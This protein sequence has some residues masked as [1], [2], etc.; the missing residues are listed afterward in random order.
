M[1][2]DANA[3]ELSGNSNTPKL[4]DDANA[5]EL[6]DE[7]LKA[8][9]IK[10]FNDAKKRFYSV[11]S[12]AVEKVEFDK[13]IGE[14]IRT[15]QNENAQIVEKAL[16]DGIYNYV[17][18]KGKGRCIERLNRFKTSIEEAEK[19]LANIKEKLNPKL[20]SELQSLP[21]DSSRRQDIQEQ[22]KRNKERIA[23][24][25]ISIEHDL[26]SLEDSAAHYEFFDKIN[27][28]AQKSPTPETMRQLK[29]QTKRINNAI[30]NQKEIRETLK[31]HEMDAKKAL[32]LLSK[33]EAELAQHILS[34]PPKTSIKDIEK[35]RLKEV[36]QNMLTYIQAERNKRDASIDYELSRKIMENASKNFEA[37][38]D[39]T[40]ELKKQFARL[41]KVRKTRDAYI[42]DLNDAEDR[43]LKH[44]NEGAAVA[45]SI[46]EM[47]KA[48]Q[49]E[50]DKTKKEELIAALNMKLEA[51]KREAEKIERDID[52]A[53]RLHAFTNKLMEE[54]S[55]TGDIKKLA[56]QTAELKIA[57]D[58]QKKYSDRLAN[59]EKKIANYKNSKKSH[60]KQH[61]DLR[62]AQL[63][64]EREDA[65][66]A[67]AMMGEL[68]DQA[69]EQ[70][71]TSNLSSQVKQLREGIGGK[72]KY[73]RR[74]F[75][76]TRNRLA[77]EKA[78][79][80]LLQTQIRRKKNKKDLDARSKHLAESEANLK[81]EQENV[82][83][84]PENLRSLGNLTIDNIRAVGALSVKDA[85]LTLDEKQKL[86][87]VE[88]A[89][90][91]HDLG[92]K[93]L[94]KARKDKSPAKL[95]EQ[96]KLMEAAV[97][98]LNKLRK[99]LEYEEDRQLKKKNEIRKAEFE[100]TA[101]KKRHDIEKTI[102][103]GKTP[104]TED[105]INQQAIVNKHE[106]KLQRQEWE[107][108]KLKRR[109]AE[110]KIFDEKRLANAEKNARDANT[111]LRIIADPNA[112]PANVKNAKDKLAA[113]T[114][115]I[116]A[117]KKLEKKLAPPARVKERD[118]YRE[119]LEKAE[120]KR[121]EHTKKM[122]A[123][124][125]EELKIKIV[126]ANRQGTAAADA[127]LKELEEKRG[128]WL[129]IRGAQI[130][131][132]EKDAALLYEFSNKLLQESM[133]DTSREKAKALK[134]QFKALR[135][136]NNIQKDLR[137]RIKKID[138]KMNSRLYA[139]LNL[140]TK[141]QL[142]RQ[143]DDLTFGHQE[144]QKLIETALTKN[145]PDPIQLAKDCENLREGIGGRRKYT[146]RKFGQE[147]NREVLDKYESL[148]TKNKDKLKESEERLA[149]AEA[150]Q[151]E[152]PNRYRRALEHRDDRKRLQEQS[153]RRLTDA[154]S[155]YNIGKELLRKAVA[156]EPK[157]PS[158]SQRLAGLKKQFSALESAIKARNK[159]ASRL[160]KIEKNAQ[161]TKRKDAKKIKAAEK[162]LA[163]L[164]KRLEK[165]SKNL[166]KLDPNDKNYDKKLE[167][168]LAK[169]DALQEKIENQQDKIGYLKD[170]QIAN[171]TRNN[172]LIE[173][174][175]GLYTRAQGVV[176]DV[177]SGKMDEKTAKKTFD[178]MNESAKSADKA[179]KKAQR[180]QNKTYQSNIKKSRAAHRKQRLAKAAARTGSSASTS[181]SANASTISKA[182]STAT[183]A[184]SK[185]SSK[186]QSGA[187]YIKTSISDA[188]DAAKEFATKAQDAASGLKDQAVNTAKKAGA[189]IQAATSTPARAPTPAPAPRPIPPNSI[190]VPVSNSVIANNQAEHR[191]RQNKGYEI[192]PDKDGNLQLFKQDPKDPY[193]PKAGIPKG[194][195]QFETDSNGQKR[196]IVTF[197]T[198]VD[199]D[200]IKA[201]EFYAAQS[202]PNRDSFAVYPKTSPSG[203]IYNLEGQNTTTPL[204]KQYESVSTQQKTT[205]TG[206]ADMQA[207][208]KTLDKTVDNASKKADQEADKQG[209]E[210]RKP[211]YTATGRR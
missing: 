178:Q 186:I 170:Q 152:H 201:I 151:T 77:L 21:E 17:A 163:K 124:A 7:A 134:K 196:M 27:K 140:K 43:K 98:N 133:Q 160:E 156:D 53:N 146:N 35:T 28:A 49:E 135:K 106:A 179:N 78:E 66:V 192:R 15:L 189:R 167:R 138:R 122:N 128:A 153:D 30:K 20:E 85:E 58:K 166:D 13:N 99:Q 209:P 105:F 164:E 142:Q 120:A 130:E 157:N 74:A 147:R 205:L 6:S 114:K 22:I 208:D 4:S 29:K 34:N 190:S 185:V 207:R 71:D 136:V 187:N 70:E 82:K 56:K 117:E 129:K 174:A 150:T 19:E 8:Q 175:K 42:K 23:E 202:Q 137:D 10:R 33:E 115:K 11:G 101:L 184:L 182:A 46:A 61:D 59:I 54:A 126:I 14:Y 203:T 81:R 118:K 40:K 141:A 180:V 52:D 86:R 94:E 154:N 48:I 165:E 12:I 1:S 193:N 161:K 92:R 199:K 145:P 188:A 69:A 110:N 88:D 96:F 131:R 162:R 206:T 176:K 9:R 100:V 2:T 168:H 158:K 89:K 31:K 144:T 204:D 79:N 200:A 67:H 197:T 97:S 143:K 211:G 38:H 50:Q 195:V 148:D 65:I 80:N 109:E 93:I 123:L 198:P 155:D 173:Q 57:A 104:G 68:I 73:T 139:S 127:A 121:L 39:S 63:E 3:P 103:A 90:Q 45:T 91:D 210:A 171:A 119:N 172:K 18:N 16:L 125:L 116:E 95:P 132:E 113:L 169:M 177:G 32:S 181:A 72:R 149:A 44:F 60:N 84:P 102:L 107:L 26:K 112:S 194:N 51:R 108:K 183:N 76:Q 87:R 75:G 159:L 83:T 64:R 41:N 25:E 37:S 191:L 111:Y 24:L 55:K 62:K 47:N 5:P 36:S